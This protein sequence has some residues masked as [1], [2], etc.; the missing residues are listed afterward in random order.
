MKLFELSLVPTTQNSF[1]SENN[2]KNKKKQPKQC[3]YQNV[4][5]NMITTATTLFYYLF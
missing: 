2:T 4:L 3:D 5:E 1:K